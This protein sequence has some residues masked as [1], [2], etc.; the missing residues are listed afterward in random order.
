[1]VNGDGG[2]DRASLATSSR[3]LAP[4]AHPDYARTPHDATRQAPRDASPTGHELPISQALLSA[5]RE[6]A[7][8]LLN[9]VRLVVLLLL[10]GAAAAYAPSLTPARNRANVLVLAPT[11]AWAVWQALVYHRR[12]HVPSWLAIA[13][14]CVDITAVTAI[15]AGYAW[16][17]SPALALKSPIWVAYFVILAARPITSS[18]RRAAAAAVLAVAEY[19]ALIALLARSGALI[20]ASNPVSASASNRISPLDEGAKLLLLAVA[21]A[22]AAY[23]TRWH[24]HLATSYSRQALDRDRLEV[25]LAQAQLQSLKLQLHPHFLFNTLN[26]ITA[27]ISTDGAAAERMVTGL[28][29]LLRL[30]LR[31]AGEQEVPLTRELE[32]L[33]HYVGIQQIR[34]QD[35]LTVRFAVDPEA[36]CAMVPNLILQPLVENAIRHGIAPRATAGRI[37][38]HARRDNG[39]VELLVADDGV[40]VD[41]AAATAGDGIGLTNTQ[42]RLQQLYGRE[43]DFELSSGPLGGFAV[44]IRIPFHASD[45]A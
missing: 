17:Q 27:L 9:T 4:R 20:V 31:N 38:V 2:R 19:G 8:R 45:G 5:H 1:V 13:N 39:A 33:E 37:E 21:G 43:H 30:S 10:A 6:R 3:D 16:A 34:F 40:G 15:L 14:P 11:L 12:E 44:R 24:E 7:E 25:R 32:V 26:T 28:S 36:R 35:R 41:E 22:V 18:A 23:A 42:A 29:G